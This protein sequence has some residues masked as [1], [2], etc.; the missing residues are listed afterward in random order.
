HFW[1]PDVFEGASIDVSAFLSVASKGAAL[2][3]LLRVAANIPS[4]TFAI[5]IGILGAITAT[6][7]NSG[8]FVQ[9]NIKRLLGYSSIAHAGYILCAIAAAMI[10]PGDTTQAVLVYLLIYLFMNLG[11]FSVTA[12]VGESMDDFAGLG[13]RSPMLALCMTA[14]LVSLIGLPPLA[15]FN[16]KLNVMILLGSAGGWCWALVAAIGIN[17]V[18]SMYFY[19]RIVKAMYFNEGDARPSRA[20]WPA[21]ILAGMCA[22]VLVVLFIGFGPVARVAAHHGTLLSSTAAR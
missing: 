11:A 13:R 5:V 6:I 8:A 16:A 22:I 15:G 20:H 19:L 14:C 4:P 2:L 10:A 12:L 7:G 17:T 3:L 21:S 9:N 18:L 1:C